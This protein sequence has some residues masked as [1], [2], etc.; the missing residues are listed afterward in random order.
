MLQNDTRP[1]AAL[2][3]L[4]AHA[5]L[6]DAGTKTDVSTWAW[7]YDE[8]TSD[9][10]GCDPDGCTPELTRDSDAGASSR[11]SC[12]Y[13]IKSKPCRLFYSFDTPQNIVTL[14]LAFYKGDERTRSFGVKTYNA[15]RDYGSEYLTFTSSG[16]T[17]G[18]ESF[19]LNSNQTSYMYLAPRG[20][21][22]Q[23]WMSITEVIVWPSCLLGLHG[24]RPPWEPHIYRG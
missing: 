17:L 23:D 19:E 8:R 3:V 10:G 15:H 1:D 6:V 4:H 9:D 2:F 20:E 24:A 11:W 5:A 7:A 16:S 18:F 13:A 21:N 22:Y 14:D 12:N